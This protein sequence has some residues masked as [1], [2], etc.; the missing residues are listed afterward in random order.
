MIDGSGFALEWNDKLILAALKPAWDRS[1]EVL[2]R[3]FQ[4]E[5]TSN[6]WNWPRGDSPRD[7]VDTGQLR[8]SYAPQAG[9]DGDALIYD[10]AWPTEYAMA[11]HEGAKFKADNR[12]DL[13]ARRWTEEPLKNSVLERA[14]EGHAAVELGKIQ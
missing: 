9:M 4:K 11:V 3:D 8:D 12:P 13:P 1:N 14:M 7:I 2:G 10:H 6:K 5:I